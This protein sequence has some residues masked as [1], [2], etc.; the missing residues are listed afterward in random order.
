[1][2][3]K[4]HANQIDVPSDLGKQQHFEIQMVRDQKF[5]GERIVVDNHHFE[6]CEFENCNFV[7]SGGHYA[8]ANCILKGSCRFSPTG[9]A[10]KAMRLYEALLPQLGFGN[11]L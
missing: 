7:F 9:P 10:Y 3:T 2:E 5:H 6:D 11:P 1:L 8:F 4:L